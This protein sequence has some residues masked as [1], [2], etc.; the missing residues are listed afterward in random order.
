ML[1]KE[2]NWLL[3]SFLKSS[4]LNK[5]FLENFPKYP[6]FSKIQKNSKCTVGCVACDMKSY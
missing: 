2:R 5:H 3:R 4:A 6:P 1:Y